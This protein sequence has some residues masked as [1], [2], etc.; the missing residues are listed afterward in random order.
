MTGCTGT[1]RPTTLAR[2]WLA[3]HSVDRRHLHVHARVHCASTTMKGAERCKRGCRYMA[4][5]VFL[6]KPDYG[7]EVDIYSAGT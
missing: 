5:E 1:K 4:P 7:P 2:A 3:W 6:K